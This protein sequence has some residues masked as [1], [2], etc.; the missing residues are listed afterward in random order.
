VESYKVVLMSSVELQEVY[1]TL[2]PLDSRGNPGTPLRK[3]SKL[4]YGFYPAGRPIAFGIS[5]S[6]LN[7]AADGFYS[8]SV[9]AELKS[10]DPKIAPE[11]WFFHPRLGSPWPKDNG[12]KP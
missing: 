5:F 3:S 2:C 7:G 12:G 6:E 9:G 10:G 8:L 4:D 1:V 11:I